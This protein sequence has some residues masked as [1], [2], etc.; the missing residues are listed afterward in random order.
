[1][2]DDSAHCQYRCLLAT[3]ALPRLSAATLCKGPLQAVTAHAR[4]M[5]GDPLV[6]IDFKLL[7]A[8]SNTM[9]RVAGSDLRRSLAHQQVACMPDL[10]VPVELN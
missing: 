4:N 5:H 9:R 6:G 2:K 3:L 8:F 10:H 7:T 1:M